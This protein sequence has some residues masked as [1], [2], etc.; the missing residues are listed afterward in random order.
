MPPLDPMTSP[1]KVIWPDGHTCIIGPWE[2]AAENNQH[3]LFRSGRDKNLKAMYTNI[4]QFLNKREDPSC[5][6]KEQLWISIKL[7]STDVLL[8]GCVYRSRQQM[9]APPQTT[10]STYC[11]Q[12]QMAHTRIYWLLEISISRKSLGQT[13]GSNLNF[14]R[15]KFRLWHH[16]NG[17]SNALIRSG[18]QYL[19][20]ISDMHPFKHLITRLKVPITARF[21]PWL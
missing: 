10:W 11:D 17:R 16:Q 9:P 4:D 19:D 3:W 2:A 14:D 21:F 20:C 7:H 1:V 13:A 15:S 12:L 6:F 8:A 18:N 5:P